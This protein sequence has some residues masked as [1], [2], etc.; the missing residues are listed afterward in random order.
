MQF[1]AYIEPIGSMA[2]WEAGGKLTVWSEVESGTEVELSI[3][4]SRAY[5][6]ST[7]RRRSWL[8]ERLLGK[9]TKLKS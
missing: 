1:H 8:A 5:E 6:T 2:T 7:P 4:A 9:E 3:P